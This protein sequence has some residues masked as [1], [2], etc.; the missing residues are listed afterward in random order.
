ME[1]YHLGRGRGRMGEKVQILRSINGRYK[2]GDVKNNTGHGEAKELL[3]MTH[4]HEFR[5]DC[6]KKWGYW[7]GSGAEGEKLGQL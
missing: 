6:W 2:I 3:C 7:A 1:G 4:E 5:G